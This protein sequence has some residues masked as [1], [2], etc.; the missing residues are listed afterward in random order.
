MVVFVTPFHGNFWSYTK[1]FLYLWILHI[2]LC[3]ITYIFFSIRLNCCSFALLILCFPKSTTSSS[4]WIHSDQI[5]TAM[6]YLKRLVSTVHTLSPII[7]SLDENEK[8]FG[9]FF[10][11]PPQVHIG[12]NPSKIQMAH[13]CRF[14]LITNHLHVLM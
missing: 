5:V 10:C 6:C 1:K 4:F 12:D 8:I 13:I 11:A 7:F 14:F 2:F 9:I 3:E